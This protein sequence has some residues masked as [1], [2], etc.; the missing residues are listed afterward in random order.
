MAELVIRLVFSL[1][2]VVGL[3]IL[4]SRVVGRRF[5]GTSRS[6]VRVLHRQP[7]SRSTAVAVVSVGSRVL[8]LGTTEHQVSLLAELSPEEAEAAREPA[9]TG[10]HDRLGAQDAHETD[11]DFERDLQDALTADVHRAPALPLGRTRL[12]GSLLAPQTW[13][14]AVTAARGR[15]R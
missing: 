9:P 12:T 2:V 13:R 8:V 14:D 6:V 1:A 11:D 7:L 4:I 5:G 10:R 15:A 3:L